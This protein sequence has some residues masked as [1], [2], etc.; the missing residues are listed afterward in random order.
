MLWELYSYRPHKENRAIYVKW[1]NDSFPFGQQVVNSEEKSKREESLMCFSLLPEAVSKFYFFGGRGVGAGCI[2]SMQKLLGKGW[3]P[4][5]SSDNTR[6]SS[7]WATRKLK[8][9]NFWEEWRKR[10]RDSMQLEKFQVYQHTWN[11]KSRKKG[12]KERSSI[13][14]AFVFYTLNVYVCM[15]IIPQWKWTKLESLLRID[16]GENNVRNQLM[17]FSSISFDLSVVI[18]KWKYISKSFPLVWVFTCLCS[19]ESLIH[20]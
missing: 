8:F 12:E 2:C 5:Y 16:Q 11:G 14:F 10:N 4:H 6:F 19:F 13:V 15:S 7:C 3:S 20:L 9:Q 18:W 17:S 1:W